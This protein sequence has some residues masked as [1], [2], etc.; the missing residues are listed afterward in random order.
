MALRAKPWETVANTAYNVALQRIERARFQGKK[1]LDLTDLKALDR[2]PDGISSLTNLPVLY[3]SGTKVADLTPLAGLAGLQRLLFSDTRVSDLTPLAGLSNLQLLDFSG[4]LVTENLKLEVEPGVTLDGLA[5]AQTPGLAPLAGLTRLQDLRFSRTRISDLTP[6][7]GLTGLR[8]LIFEGTRVT[9]LAPLARLTRLQVLMFDETQVADL[10]PLAGLSN[11]QNLH[12]SYCPN[13]ADPILIELSKQDDPERTIE[14]LRYL[15]ERATKR[16]EEVGASAPSVPSQSIAP[17]KFAYEGDI[18]KALSSHG[19]SSDSDKARNRAREAYDALKEMVEEIHQNMA[20]G[21]FPRVSQALA[22]YSRA[23]GRDFEQFRQIA[24]GIAAERLKAQ[25]AVAHEFMPDDLAA[26]LKGL[27]ASHALFAQLFDE[28]QEF[29]KDI[30]KQEI[31]P[32]KAEA[33]RPAAQGII[34][35]FR[36]SANIDPGVPKELGELEEN[37]ADG[38]AQVQEASQGFY[39]SLGNGLIS[40]AMR[41]RDEANKFT[42]EVRANFRTEAAKKVAWAPFAVLWDTLIGSPH[43]TQLAAHLPDIVPWLEAFIDWWK[44][45]PRGK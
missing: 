31:D 4:T 34:E 17:L 45:L 14:T 29:L 35:A 26:D 1:H 22:A 39:R 13:I 19:V 11:L 25:A 23:L 20:S 44:H 7:A 18:L 42:R 30:K 41:A 33:A 9:D 12:F 16:E 28:W 27:T 10:T 6:L 5:L 15:R 2:L 43:L 38:G 21:N 36:N 32:A 24:L 3:L 40:V 37:L 8:I